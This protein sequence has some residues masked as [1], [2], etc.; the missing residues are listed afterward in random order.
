MAS[1]ARI[2]LAVFLMVLFGASATASADVRSFKPVRATRHMLTFK[3]RGLEPAAIRHAK[4][5]ARGVRRSVALRT[6]RR[7]ARRGA[8]RVRTPSL[9][10]RIARAG[11]ARA[12]AASLTVA[13]CSSSSSSYAAAIAGTPGLVSENDIRSV[14]KKY[15]ALCQKPPV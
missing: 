15:L 12:G 14:P 10:P 3:L 8:L 2:P 6:I 13:T 7:A 11:I 9:G 5:R 4:L 1:R